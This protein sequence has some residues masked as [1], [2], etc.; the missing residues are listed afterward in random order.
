MEAY[1]VITYEIIDQSNRENA[2][3][4]IKE[5]W[6][7]NIIVSNGVAHDAKFLDGIMAKENGIP[8]GLITYLICN[9]ECEIITLDSMKEGIGIGTT[10]INK[11]IEMAKKNQCKRAWLITTNDNIDAI[12]FYQKR[13]FD[14]V[15][16]HRN[17][18]VEARKIKPSIPQYGCYAIEIKHEL[19]F[20]YILK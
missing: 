5:S 17:M 7:S 19:E 11:V 15:S 16:V 13:S 20:E 6:G 9:Q 4:I 2:L 8:C 1:I 10:L 12:R 14:F 3:N 18:I